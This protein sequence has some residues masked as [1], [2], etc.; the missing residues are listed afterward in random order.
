VN[1]EKKES[2][3]QKTGGKR[4]SLRAAAR[5]KRRTYYAMGPARTETNKKKRVRKQVRANPFDLQ[6][7]AR[8]EQTFGR[9]SDLGLNARGRK[10]K[11]RRTRSLLTMASSD[12]NNGPCPS[13]TTA[14]S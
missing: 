5:A 13:P 4:A 1:Q 6:A 3:D 11:R 8:Y 9:A 10:L 7:I 2:K 12:N 14:A